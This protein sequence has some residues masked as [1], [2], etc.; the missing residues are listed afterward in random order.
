MQG[1]IIKG[2]AGFYYVNIDKKGTF[3]CKAKGAFRN[4]GTKPLVGDN[5]EIDVIDEEKKLGNI[6]SI[7]ERKSE[8]IRPACANVDQALIIFAIKS[9][10]PNFNLLDRFL[11]YME[12]E[13]VPCL[14][15]FN[16]DDLADSED[17]EAIR[18]AYINA[19]Y[20]LL[21]TSAKDS[22]G[23]DALKDILE[24][25]TTVVAGPSGVGK[26]TIVNLLCEKN[27][28]ETGTISE[29]TERG[30]HTTRHAELLP[31]KEGTYIMDTPGFTSLDV[32]GAD[33]SSLADY[34]NEFEPYVPFCRFLDC[35]H[36]NEP[37]CEVKN[38]VEDGTISKMRYANYC[39][40]MEDI[41]ISEANR[42]K[43]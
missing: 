21:F 20:P 29:K 30:R 2:I 8:M 31:I 6:V 3:E 34:Y 42:F 11:I 40:L 33:S 1:K 26:S 5:V 25:K 18:Q 41:K 4:E 24:N 27:V 13:N 37:G 35:K 12:S 17:A 39:Q 28:M 32:F 22:V 36:I 38:K 16:K 14:I 19:G 9:P 15:C 10:D 43:R 23:I 7:L